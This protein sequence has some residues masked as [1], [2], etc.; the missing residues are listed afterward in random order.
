MTPHRPGLQDTV[1]L[2][3]APLSPTVHPTPFPPL[4]SA[5]FQALKLSLANCK[6][7]Y[8]TSRASSS[9]QRCARGLR[10]A[11]SVRIV[12]EIVSIDIMI[13]YVPPYHSAA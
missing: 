12:L 10:T 11:R 3:D 13:R 4:N 5:L 2:C 7:F 1:P 8:L 6:R 9:V